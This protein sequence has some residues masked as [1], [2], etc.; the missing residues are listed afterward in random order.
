MKK[1]TFKQIR[2]MFFECH[3]QFAHERRYRKSQNEYSTDCRCAFV[4][5]VDS[6]HKDGTITDKQS[7]GITLG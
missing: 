1:Y 3:P 5:F 7:F 6:L 2:D 4:D